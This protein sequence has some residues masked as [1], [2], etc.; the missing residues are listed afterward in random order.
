MSLNSLDSLDMSKSSK[1]LDAPESFELRIEFSGLCLFVVDNESQQVGIL[2]PDA[3]RTPSMEAMQHIDGSDAVPHAGYLRFD[4]GDMEGAK[5]PRG[6][7][8]ISGPRYEAVHRFNCEELDLGLGNAESDVDASELTFPDFGEID[9]TLKLKPGMFGGSPPKE[10]LMRTKLTGGKFTTHSGG[11]NWTFPD[12]VNRQG[13]LYQGQFANYATWTGKINA[14]SVTLTIT[15][16][17]NGVAPTSLT[18][19]PKE[20]GGVVLLKVVN[21]CAENPLEWDALKIRTIEGEED[22]DFKWLY[23]LLD[24]TGSVLPAPGDQLPIPI[25]DRSSG[26]AGEE[27]DCTGGTISA[28]T[29]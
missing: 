20:K 21:L 2:M 25:L 16:F 19:R 17:G 29:H 8:T 12:I 14:P 5:V 24:N 28:P 9:N 15:P 1:S 6:S 22:A 27:Q 23:D 11:S 3:R 7:N 10:L 13:N 4:L 18:L 26:A